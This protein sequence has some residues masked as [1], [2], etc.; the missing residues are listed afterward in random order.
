DFRAVRIA[1]ASPRDVLEWSSG[2]VTRPDT[3][4]YRTHRPEKGGL[5]CE[6]IF[7]PEKDWEC[8]CGK[9]RG[10]K[11]RGSACP[12]CG[13]QGAHSR[14]RRKRMGHIELAAPVV[15]I[16]FFKG[17]PSVLGQLL[18]LKRAELQRVVYHQAHLVTDPGP[19]GLALAEV[20]S[21]DEL[22]HQRE[23]HGGAF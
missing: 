9:Y 4:N 5:F 7:G 11:Y 22:R 12:Q 6:R 1:L 18:D 20:M 2:E 23:R 17:V 16:W 10:I 3:I 13:V 19:T 15:H 8:S 14:V 21:D